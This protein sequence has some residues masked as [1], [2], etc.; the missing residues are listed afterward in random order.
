MM[1]SWSE[2]KRYPKAA[3]GESI[4]APIGPGLYEVRHAA[5]GALFAF[6]AVDNLA[7]ALAVLHTEPKSL[8]SWF[9]KREPVLLPDLDYRTCATSTKADARIAAE[10]MLGRRENYMRGAAA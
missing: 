5:S 3:R 6:G 8:V 7:Q 4:E 10:S 9:T 1:Q 2:W